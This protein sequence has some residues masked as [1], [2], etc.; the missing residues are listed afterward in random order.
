MAERAGG[1]PGC[2]PPQ[3]QHSWAQFEFDWTAVAGEHTITTRATDIEGN[4]QPDRVPFNQKGYL[5]NQPL[6]HPVL[7][8]A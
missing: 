8:T 1:T 6:P 3:P 2:S 4:T 7:V 5:F